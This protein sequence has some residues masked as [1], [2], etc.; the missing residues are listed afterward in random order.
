MRRP[1]LAAPVSLFLAGRLTDVF[2]FGL[3][4]L[5]PDC[6]A[7]R[8]RHQA[9]LLQPRRRPCTGGHPYASY[10]GRCVGA[11]AVSACSCRL[12]RSLGRLLRLPP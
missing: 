8:H 5:E 9:P 1:R 7:H 3:P 10:R 11:T 4:I 12:S 6:I 2:F